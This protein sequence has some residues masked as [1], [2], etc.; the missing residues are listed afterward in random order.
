MNAKLLF[1]ATVAL[2]IA[3]TYAMADP[4]ST[5]LSRD[6]VVS[7]LQQA[8]T[9]GTLRKTDYDD[10]LTQTATGPSQSRSA[11]IAELN[12]S[13]AAPKP[14]GPLANRTYN[15]NSSE[16]LK[17]SVVSRSQVNYDVREAMASGTLLRTDY[18]TDPQVLARHAR[19]HEAG[20]ALFARLR[21][22]NQPDVVSQARSG[23]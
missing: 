15:Q 21:G 20:E 12:A 7:E 10:A 5:A 23:R 14:L 8:T 22:G 18:D 11:V 17:P 19:A 13:L 3:S 2:S 1:A 9:N 6:Q 16:L 4:S